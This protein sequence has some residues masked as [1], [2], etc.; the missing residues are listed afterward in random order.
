M[1][2]PA[3]TAASGTPLVLEDV[4]PQDGDPLVSNGTDGNGT[5]G[6]LHYVIPEALTPS[7]PPLPAD[8]PED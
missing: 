5:N 4:Y 7:P 6:A 1:T 3:G 2:L 8:D